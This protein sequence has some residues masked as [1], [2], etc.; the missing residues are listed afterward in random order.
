MMRLSLN[1]VVLSLLAGCNYIFTPDVDWTERSRMSSSEA[2]SFEMFYQG[3]PNPPVI[4]ES[5]YEG[6]VSA[7]SKNEYKDLRNKL[8][9][10]F[11]TNY[12]LWAYYFMD[13]DGDE[14]G[15]WHWDN[16][17][18][19]FVAV[20]EDIDGDGISNIEDQD[21]YNKNIKNN[22]TDRDGIPNHLDWDKNND[23]KSDVA[24]VSNR[25]AYE[26]KI[27]K[28]KYDLIA[29][30]QDGLHNERTLVTFKEVLNLGYKK[31]FLDNQGKFPGLRYVA[32]QKG[33]PEGTTLAWFR[34]ISKMI[35]ILDSGRK[36]GVNEVF[37]GITPLPFYATVIHELAHALKHYLEYKDGRDI[38]GED[39]LGTYWSKKGEENLFKGKTKKKWKELINTEIDEAIDQYKLSD[40]RSLVSYFYQFNKKNLTY[41]LTNVASENGIISLYSL[42]SP[43][44]YFAEAVPAYAFKVIV[45]KR[46]S[47]L[48]ESRRTKA[49]KRLERLVQFESG[50]NI[51]T[52]P[53]N[54][55]NVIESELELEKNIYFD[56]TFDRGNG[57]K[58]KWRR[59]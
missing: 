44:E 5:D 20:D 8:L 19:K 39:I 13:M 14:I 36:E 49:T 48:S 47:H 2:K 37:S 15:D 24:G 18:K 41:S 46:F 35:T 17:D 30:N 33:E 59:N 10:Y 6:Y 55:E 4:I 27:L 12:T 31:V 25:M 23:G 34:K 53:E 54:L 29:V 38:V 16:E 45:N 40:D 50:L 22:D 21:P 26:Q 58:G 56:R 51:N 11:G 43:G 9:N 7:L 28:F 42:T 52:I 32:A 1:L 3:N 57:L